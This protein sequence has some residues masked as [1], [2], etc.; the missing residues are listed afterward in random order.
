MLERRKD[1]GLWDYPAGSMDLGESLDETA[2]RE[3]FEETGLTAQKLEL[4]EFL[5]SDTPCNVYP[6]GDIVYNVIGRYVC[7]EWTG[8][9]RPQASE[10]TDLCWFSFDA[11]PENLAPGKA[12]KIEEYLEWRDAKA[13]L[14][15]TDS[16]GINGGFWSA[17]DKLIIESKIVIDRPKGTKHP[18]FDFIYPL[19]Y[20]YLENT[21]S[22]D[23]GGIDVWRGSMNTDLCDAVICTVD[24][25]KKDSE[26]KLLIGC[27]EVEKDSIL[28]FHNESEL[29]KGA[30][31]RRETP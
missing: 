20:G 4:Y 14:L 22:M 21:S 27:T 18:R 2:K 8:E 24:L 11:L 10:V 12:K 30:M 15:A 19:D 13:I 16:N 26:I 23:G 1:N 17:I 29:M 6:N 31:I 28:R 5:H 7:T 25:L 9:L 3:L